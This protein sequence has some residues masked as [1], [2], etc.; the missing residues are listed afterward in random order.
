[1]NIPDVVHYIHVSLLI[2]G[3]II[4]FVNDESML[5]IYS[6]VIPFLFFHWSTNDD[7]CAITMLEQ[8][9]RGETDK[10]KT[11]VGQ[12]MTGVYVLPEDTLGRALKF[13]FFSLWMFVQYR[14][15]RLIDM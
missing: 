3:L 8:Y 13:I 4:P 10:H 15:G 14:L 5:S 9:L 6:F 7:T 12:V 2:L 1:M 11:F